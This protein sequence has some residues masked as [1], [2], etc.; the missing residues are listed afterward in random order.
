[1]DPTTVNVI[2]SKKDLSDKSDG[3]DVGYIIGTIFGIIGTIII[4]AA[5]CYCCVKGK[6]DGNCLKQSYNYEDEYEYEYVP[7]IAKIKKRKN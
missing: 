6:C 3:S 7:A 1:M 4:I 2:F 5:I